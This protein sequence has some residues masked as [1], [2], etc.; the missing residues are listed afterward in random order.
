M[1]STAHSIEH[2]RVF[3]RRDPE[4]PRIWISSKPVARVEISATAL[5]DLDRLIRSHSLPPNTR[6]RVR[7]GL[8][9]L[10]GFPLIGAELSGRWSGFRFL[11]GPW[12]W[13][14]VVYVYFEDENRV[15]IA[16]IQDGRSSRLS[17]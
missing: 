1:A 12:R 10:R 11:L 8:E 5:E 17:S 9:P 16:T 7:R 2:S 14:I 15:V 3:G 4:T 13:M 6:E